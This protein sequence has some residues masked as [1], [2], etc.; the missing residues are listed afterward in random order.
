[1]AVL[2]PAK[3]PRRFLVYHPSWG[4]FAQEYGLVQIAI[5]AE[6]KEPSAKRL[7]ERKVKRVVF[8][9]LDPNPA[10]CGKGER[11]LRAHGIVVDRFPE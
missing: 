7:I 11:L 8:G 6:G 1:M 3:P 9:M 5:E 4:Y 2:L 10:I